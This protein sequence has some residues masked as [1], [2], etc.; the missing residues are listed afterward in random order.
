MADQGSS[1]P[2]TSV[3]ARLMCPTGRLPFAPSSVREAAPWL[4]TLRLAS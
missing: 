2:S 3:A 4:E 1:Y